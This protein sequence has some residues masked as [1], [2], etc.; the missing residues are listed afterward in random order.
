MAN[1]EANVVEELIRP[2][3]GVV[4]DVDGWTMEGA[5]RDMRQNTR[6]EDTS[7]PSEFIRQS[8]FVF[9][10]MFHVP[11]YIVAQSRVILDEGGGYRDFDILKRVFPDLD[12]E[13]NSLF[14]NLSFLVYAGDISYNESIDLKLQV[15]I[16]SIMDRRFDENFAAFFGPEQNAASLHRKLN[17]F[18]LDL[19]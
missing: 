15:Q 7:S 16:P 19:L 12:F 10:Q 4:R 3:R 8:R 6:F 13:F 5:I 1:V 14:E 18:I 2:A 17:F 11:Q 9:G